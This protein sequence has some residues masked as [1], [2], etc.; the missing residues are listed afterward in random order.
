[1]API[2]SRQT[3]KD[4]HRN[5]NKQKCRERELHILIHGKRR[6]GGLLACSRWRRLH[7][8]TGDVCAITIHIVIPLT[9]MNS[10]IKGFC[11]RQR[12]F[13]RGVKGS[14]D[15]LYLRLYGLVIGKNN[16]RLVIRCVD[17]IENIFGILALKVTCK[18]TVWITFH[19]R[20]CQY[21]TKYFW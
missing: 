19:Y 2:I 13:N 5:G 21:N 15:L 17:F 4:H 9:C 11:C 6:R 20:K 16:T 7:L 14:R 1:M 18:E 10:V 3:I 12:H 8:H